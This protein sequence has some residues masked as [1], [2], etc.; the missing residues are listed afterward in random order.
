MGGRVGLREIKRA[1]VVATLAISY[2]VTF[3]SLLCDTVL[4][5]SLVETE[6]AG[7]L[8]TACSIL[9]CN[10]RLGHNSCPPI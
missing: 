2:T 7:S 10:K 3:P 1:D 4:Y 8:V 6:C 9:S 5:I